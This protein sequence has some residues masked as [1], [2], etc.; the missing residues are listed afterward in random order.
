MIT[1]P[2]SLVT[3][4]PVALKFQIELEFGNIGC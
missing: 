2:N 3:D 4:K 1:K